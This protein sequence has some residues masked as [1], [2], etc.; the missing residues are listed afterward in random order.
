MSKP[1]RHQLDA[2]YGVT[3]IVIHRT[4]MRLNTPTEQQLLRMHHKRIETCNS[5]LE[6]MDVARLHARLPVPRSKL[7]HHSVL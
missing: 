3:M 4:N 7:L 2:R 6:K 1:L 5:Q